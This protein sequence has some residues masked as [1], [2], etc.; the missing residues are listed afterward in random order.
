MRSLPLVLLALIPLASAPASGAPQAGRDS[1]ERLLERQREARA[2]ELAKLEGDARAYLEGFARL[3]PPVPPEREA[4]LVNQLTGLGPAAGTLLVPYLAPGPGAE[5]VLRV[6]ARAVASA[7]AHLGDVST[8]DALLELVHSGDE[9]AVR[10]ALRALE[11]CAEPERAR[12]QLLALF[13]SDTGRLRAS[14]LTT[15]VR[16]GG[17]G[18]EA[19]F[20]RVLSD[21]DVSLRRLGL[22][23]LVEAQSSAAEAQVRALMARPGEA[24]SHIDQLLAYYTAMPE[25]VDAEVLGLWVRLVLRTSKSEDRMRILDALPG[26]GAGT[27]SALRR[28][29]EPLTDSGDPAVVEAARIALARL[30]DRNARREVLRT[31]DEFVDKNERFPGAYTRRAEVHMRLHDWDD[32]IKDYETALRHGRNDGD[33]LDDAY[34][35]L[36]RACARKGKLKDAAEWLR[37][38]PIQMSELR[39]LADDPDFRELRE[40][41]FAKDVWGE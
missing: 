33:R 34:L 9:D 24:V 21:P 28:E 35:G 12:P 7:L 30:G 13:E 20:A 27:G 14:L 1:L 23:A 2:R 18:S 39:A 8:T 10:N 15:L 38:A 16:M 3:Q 11:G 31:Y 19:V 25:Q 17:T 36:A 4:E 26:L 5:E 37:K 32:A 29:L 6:R 41:R 40:S 22:G